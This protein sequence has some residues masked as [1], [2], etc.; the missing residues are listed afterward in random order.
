MSTVYLNGEFLP[1]NAA[2]V[3]VLD[4]GFI[5]G[6]GVY[7]VIPAYQGN[8]FRLNEHLARLQNSL[9][10]I[11]IKNPYT[12]DQWQNM[13]AELVTKNGGG[14]LSVYLQVTR[15]SAQ[16]DHALPANV[17]PTVF[18]MAN[19]LQ[20]PKPQD[21]QN[22]I[23][24]ITTVDDRWLN[25]H[26]KAIS[27]LPNVLLRQKAIDAGATEAILLRNGEAT[28]GA[29]SNLFIVENNVLIT[30]PNGPCLL[31][32]ITRDVILE[33]AQKAHISCKE[34][35]I[36]EQQLREADEIWITSSTKEIMPV[37]SL[38]NEPVGNG[39]PGPLWHQVVELFQQFKE[40][41]RR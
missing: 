41:M 40:S 34:A 32:G 3:S 7:E 20:P 36:S 35:P 16:R 38:D 26:I 33:L 37:T 24:A 30:P 31:P 29:A 15:G 8:L 27:L 21:L 23:K 12:N 13:L 1:D 2:C 28:E 10:A 19:P 5:F 17:E 11:R 22:G 4:R 14:D 25:C 6:D 18:A 39:K 9:D